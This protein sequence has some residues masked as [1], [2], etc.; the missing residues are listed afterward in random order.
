[1]PEW[2]PGL[3]FTC[4]A[5]ARFVILDFDLEL[6]AGPEVDDL[7][8]FGFLIV[9]VLEGAI[10]E[11]CDQ[12]SIVVGKFFRLRVKRSSGE[13]GSVNF[14]RENSTEDV[15]RSSPQNRRHHWMNMD[16]SFHAHASRRVRSLHNSLRVARLLRKKLD[17]P[18]SNLASNNSLMCR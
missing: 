9:E 1:M 6:E 7:R 13:A 15:P 4:F 18:D 14:S 11:A 2:T 5:G 17:T 8:A 16:K 10:I 12:P 3:V